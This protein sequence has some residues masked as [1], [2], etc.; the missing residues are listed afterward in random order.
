MWLPSL[1]AQFIKTLNIEQCEG[2]NTKKTPFE[3]NVAVEGGNFPSKKT[4]TDLCTSRALLDSM[5]LKYICL[6]FEIYLSK[7]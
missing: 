6:N 2:I 5:V 4:V 7:F 3:M 1:A